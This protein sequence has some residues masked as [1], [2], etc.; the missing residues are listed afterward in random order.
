M[1]TSLQHGVQ[2]ALRLS[3]RNPGYIGLI[4]VCGVGME[5]S[6]IERSIPS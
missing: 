4:V 5:L 1:M 6:H 2:S 3:R